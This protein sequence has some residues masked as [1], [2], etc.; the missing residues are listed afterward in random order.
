[1]TATDEV[2]NPAR[3]KNSQLDLKDFLSGLLASLVGCLPMGEL[4]KKIS[5][6]YSTI[7]VRLKIETSIYFST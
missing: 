2:K 6:M 1:M 4:N 7:A 5:T 3:K